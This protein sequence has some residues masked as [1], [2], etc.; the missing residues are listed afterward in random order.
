LKKGIL[1]FCFLILYALGYSQTYNGTVIRVI[2]GDTYVFQ[3]EDGSF[4]VRMQG[5]DAPERDQPFSKE[6]AEFLS[7]Y[8]DKEAITKVNGTDR[9]GRRLGFLFIAGQDINL[10]SIEG[11]YSWHSK[12]YSS[13]QQY[14]N[15]ED[16]AR[17]NKSGLWKLDNPVPPWNWRQK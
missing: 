5:I 10:L 4:I 16:Y 14:A 1:T 15:A 8:L 11:G 9:Y 17:K 6:S 7:K 3:T 2:D 12:R 13:D